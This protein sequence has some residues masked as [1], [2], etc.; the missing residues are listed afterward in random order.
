MIHVITS[1][2]VHSNAAETMCELGKL[3]A[4]AFKQLFKGI[5]WLELKETPF[6]RVMFPK[7]SEVM[8]LS[9]LA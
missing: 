7:G 5:S 6:L 4:N 9:F 1:I 3:L 2:E 8:L